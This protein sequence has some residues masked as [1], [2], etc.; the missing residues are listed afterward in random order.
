MPSI[1]VCPSILSIHS[2]VTDQAP[3]VSLQLYPNAIYNVFLATGI[4]L[5]RWRRKKADLPEP[6]FK[7][8]HIVI[9]FNILVNL[10]L[11]VMPWYPPPGGANAG[12]FSFWYGTANVTGIGM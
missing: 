10:Y 8:W 9:L 6:Q 12:N 1:L 2:T 3:A 7:S 5:V 11:V 4:Y